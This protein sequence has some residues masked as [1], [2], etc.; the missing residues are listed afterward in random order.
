MNKKNVLLGVTAGVAVYKSCELVR[1]MRRDG[2]DVKVMMTPNAAELI[3]P[4]LFETLSCNPVY[5]EM[6]K[7]QA[8]YSVEHI[9]LAEWAQACVIAPCTLA[10][11]SKVAHGICDNLLTTVVMALTKNTPIILA[12]AMNDN[13][14]NNP[15][16]SENVEK[17]KRLLNVTIVGPGTGELACG[18]TGAGRMAEIDEI[19]AAVRG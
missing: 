11:L 12:P 14:W 4:Y 13:M 15:V 3:S 19:V 9:S 2:Y 6:F 5:V 1:R 10:T 7:R 18:T 8:D 17:L 16:T